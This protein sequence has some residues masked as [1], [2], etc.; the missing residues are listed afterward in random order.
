LNGVIG[1]KAADLDAVLDRIGEITVAVSG[2]VDSMTL[3]VAAGRRLGSRAKMVHA[4][5]PAVPPEA[6]AR[7]RAYAERENWRLEVIDAG[8]FGDPNYLK[9]PSN[10]CYFCKTNLY[11][12]IAARTSA[13]I[14]SGTNVDDLGDFRPGLEAAAEHGVRHPYVEAGI[15]KATVRALAG[16]WG[17]HD[18]AELPAAPCL[19]SRLETGIVVTAAKL[20]LVHAVE[21][22]IERELSPQT[23]RCRV[24]HDGIAIQL[25]QTSLEWV[26][27]SQGVTLRRAV[28]EVLAAHGEGSAARYQPYRMGS[29]FHQP[30]SARAHAE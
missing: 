30:S 29:A 2:G 22:L 25:D 19:S 11:D 16:Q 15:D 9:N 8:E 1:T 24:F 10:R 21:R 27:G 28:E 17:L 14:V 26:Q 20:R 4:V 13:T 5:S 6:T 3:A 23:V 12:A 7:V 18:L